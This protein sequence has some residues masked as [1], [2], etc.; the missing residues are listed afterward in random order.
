MIFL[1]LADQWSA[2]C[3]SWQTG[4]HPEGPTCAID[5]VVSSHCPATSPALVGQ[6]TSN[7][8]VLWS[9]DNPQILLNSASKR[10]MGF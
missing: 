1:F 8:Q 4:R 3:I 10:E 6:S 2:V 5:T 7:S 9:L